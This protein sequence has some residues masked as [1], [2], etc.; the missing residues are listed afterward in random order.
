MAVTVLFQRR[1]IWNFFRLENEH[2]S[3]VG[4]FLAA[5]L[6]DIRMEREEDTRKGKGTVV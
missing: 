1:I 4:Q 5:D 2:T 6:S 3:N